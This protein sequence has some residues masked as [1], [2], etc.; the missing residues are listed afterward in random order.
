MASRRE[1]NAA[2]ILKVNG[3]GV[4]RGSVRVSGSPNNSATEPTRG[5]EL[6]NLAIELSTHG[7]G[8]SNTHSTQESAAQAKRMIARNAGKRG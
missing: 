6:R 1:G 3:E 8:S 2:G 5:K 4:H 7:G